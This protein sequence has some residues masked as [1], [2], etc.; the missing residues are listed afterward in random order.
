M[1]HWTKQGKGFI[2]LFWDRAS[3]HTTGRTRRWI[4]A[5]NRRAK[6]RRLTGLILYTLPI[7]LDQAPGSRRSS[8]RHHGRTARS[9]DV[10]LPSASSPGSISPLFR[11]GQGAG[12]RY[13]KTQGLYGE[14]AL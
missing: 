12:C 7:Q 14:S 10:S 2:V 4:R 8:L 13:L 9:G 1:A 6:K 5:Y 3:W 11:L